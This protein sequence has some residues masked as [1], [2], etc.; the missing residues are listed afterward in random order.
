M[1]VAAKKRSSGQLRLWKT[2]DHG[3]LVEKFQRVTKGQKL[4]SNS[5]LLQPRP[6]ALK[7]SHDTYLNTYSFENP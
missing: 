2:R 6:L 4:G 3:G 5:L 7:A 1:T